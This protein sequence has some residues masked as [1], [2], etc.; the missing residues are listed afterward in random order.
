MDVFS[1][2]VKMRCV[3]CEIINNVNLFHSLV[4]CQVLTVNFSHQSLLVINLIW[5]CTFCFLYSPSDATLRDIMQVKQYLLSTG[6]CKCGLPCPIRPE[7]FFD[8]N[9]EVSSRHLDGSPFFKKKTL[10]KKFCMKTRLRV[11]CTSSSSWQ[12]FWIK[13]VSKGLQNGKFI[14]NA[15]RFFIHLSV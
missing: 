5:F 15:I 14:K 1:L 12:S 9:I 2:L 6:T 11:H 7:S 13:L 10:D 3:L 8:F 4:S